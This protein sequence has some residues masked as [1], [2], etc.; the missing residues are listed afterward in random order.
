MRFRTSAVARFA[1]TT[2]RS[3]GASGMGSLRLFAFGSWLAVKK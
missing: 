1:S 2:P 3:G